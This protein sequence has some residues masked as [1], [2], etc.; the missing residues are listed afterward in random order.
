MLLAALF[1]MAPA[2]SWGH[3]EEA[4]VAVQTYTPIVV[5]GT[6]T[7]WARRLER[8]DWSARLKV[9][10]G[11]VLEWMRAVP[12]YL[13]TLTAR[14]EAGS[15]SGPAD[16]SAVVY[17]LWDPTYL[18]L[19]AAVE[20]DEL[21][22]EHE[23]EDIWQDDTLEFWFDCRHDAV[24]HTLFQDDEYQIG[25]S[26]AGPQRNT[27]VGWV[28]R[29]PKTEVVRQALEVASALTPGG[30][31]VEARVPWAV[32]QGCRP[33]IGGMIGFNISA[34]D[35]DADQLWTHLT[36][37][38]KLHSDPS[39]FGHLYFMD[40]PVDLFPSD[41]FEGTPAPVPWEDSSGGIDAP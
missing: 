26:P 11:N 28:W 14:V 3:S 27:P 18:Y 40:A 37:S 13:N 22:T 7:E 35:K 19:A 38:G 39:Q 16:F 10:G 25:V 23:G 32:L 17:A 5:D 9:Q 21:M 8:S 4:G 12:M 31:L 1:W 6:L 30:Y 36:W 34:V 15:V 20:D 33:A 2:V 29:N 41:V 24:T